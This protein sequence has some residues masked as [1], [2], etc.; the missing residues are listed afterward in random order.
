[1]KPFYNLRLL[2]STLKRFAQLAQP[3]AAAKFYQA[4]NPQ[5]QII[6]KPILAATR[7]NK[8]MAQKAFLLLVM[9]SFSMTLFGQ[10][11]TI[12][13]FSPAS[14][15]VG[16]LV[17]ING[18]N[19]SSPTAFSIGGVT[20]LVINNTGAVLTGFVMPG[21]VTGAISLTTGGGTA[22]GSGNFTVTQTSYPSVQQGGE[23]TGTGN[24]GGADQGYSLSLSAD[25]NTAIVGGNQDN[26]QQGA[27][28]IYTRNGG[29]WNQQGGKLVG[30]G[31]TGPAGQGCSV[32][33]SADGNTAIVGGNQD[34]NGEG[35]AWVFT[36]SGGVWGQ[37]GGKLVGTG[38]TGAAQQGVS[39]SLSADGNT[40]MMGGV[41][42][43]SNQGAAWVFTR[44]GG[45]WGQQG[46]KL[47][48]SD[49]TGAAQQ[50]ISVSLSADGNTAIVGGNQDNN[51]EGAAWV[52]TRS[53]GVWGQQG[54][55]LVGTG[56]TG[57]ANQGGSVSL[58]ADGNTAMVGGFSDNSNQGGAWVFTR[59]RGVWGQQGTELVGTGN[60]GEAEQGYSVSLSADGNTA[61]VGGFLDNSNQGAAWV[62]TRS[63]GVWG[64]QG[65][66]LV[67]TG[68]TGAAWQGFSVSLSADG[69]T[70][71]AGGPFDNNYQGGAWVFAIA[72]APVITSFS[73]SSGAVGTLVTING[74][75]L[76]DQRIFSIGGVTA[77]V[78]NNT[79]TVLT[80]FVMPGAVTG[81]ISLTTGG[82]TATGSGNFTV[83]P[84]SY[85][86][87]QQGGK[88]T[89][90]DYTGQADQGY[91]VAVSAG[92]NTAIVGGYYDNNQD[93]AAWIYTR[94]GGV[95]SQQGGKLVGTG[96]TGAADQGISVSI[97]A[98]G[99]TAIVGGWADNGGQGAAWVFTR[100]GGVWG[101]QGAKLVGTGNTG[102]A[103]QG[104]SVSLS[105]DGNT[106]IVGGPF[107][108]GTQGAAWVYTRSNGVW[109]QQGGKLVGTGNT[110]GANQG[111]SVSLSAD[112]NTAMVGG[113]SDNNNVGASWIFTRSGGVWGQQ[114]G[115]LVGTGYTGGA[116]QGISVS[117]SADGNTAMVGGFQDYSGQG[118]A[119]V[120]TRSGG[121]WGQQGDELVGT[122]STGAQQGY[123]VSLSADGN[124]AMVG[125]PNDNG[126][127]GGA[128]V[129]TRS[130]GVWGQQGSELVGTG[131]TGVAQQG[132]SVSLSADGTTAMVGGPADNNLQGG[133]W[134]FTIAPPTIT[135]FTPSRGPVGTLVTIN[136]TN[137]G[138]PTA[139]SIG[140]VTALV[141]NNTGTVLTG[142]VMPGAVTGAI[143]LTTGDGTTTG[144]G[145]FTV[146][147]TSY[148][149]VQQGGKLTGNDNTGAAQQ[150]T[151]VA[152]SAD[153]NTAIVGGYFDNNSNGAAWIY[154][155]NG[156]VWGQQG[157]KL[158]GTG[159]TGLAEQGW[160]VAI[161]AD[162]NTAI[163]G[164]RVDN[165][166]QGAVWVFTRS[167]GVWGQQGGKLV[168]TGNI[169]GAVLGY[170][171]SLSA[172]GNTAIA[173]GTGDNGEQG[174]AWV[175][176]RS[177]GV[178]GQQGGKLVGTG[179]TGLAV[180]GWSVSL[181]ADGNTAIVGGYNDNNQQ[182]AAW[183]YTRNGGVWGQQ[184]GKLVGTGSADGANQG[185]AVSLSADG[186]TAMVAGSTDNDGEGAVWVYTRSGGAWTQQGGKLVGT[187]NAG[188]ANQGTAVS[189]S[190]DGNIALVGGN[191]DNG[192][193]GAAW[194][195][196]R[197][198]G[199]WGQQ[200]NK[201]LGTGNTGGA[202]Q[203]TSLSLSADGTTAVV[204]G[205]NDNSDQG[206]AWAYT[207]APPPAI[208]SFSPASGAVGTLVTING[209]NL[210]D[211]SNL[212]IGGVTA[213]VISNTGTVLTGFV[214]PGAVTGTVS[215]TTGGG[216]ATGSSSFTVTPTL[217][218]T[219]QQGG[220]LTASDNTGAASQGNSVAVSAD[221]NTAIVGGPNDN[222]NQGAAWVYTR[223]GGVWAQQG[224][225]L[226]GAGNTGAA[227]QGY[228]VSLSADGNTAIVGARG[229]NSSQGAAW[230][231]TRSGGVWAQQ[232]GKLV[233]TD[234]TG[235]AN[236]G[237]SVSISAD[238]NTVIEGGPDDNSSQGAAWIFTRSGGVWGQQGGKM[239]GT[240]G[241]GT[242]LQGGSVSL[243]A[244]GNTAIVGGFGDNSQEGA[245]WVFTRSGGAWGQQG[246]K[247]VGTGNTGG[248]QQGRSV[249]LSADGNTAMVGGITDNSQQG[250]AWVFTRSGGAW[251]QQGGK[252]V[253]TGNTGAA[254]QGY[255][256]S[257]S[258]DGNT[259]MVSGPADN[260]NQGAAWVYTRSGGVWGQ[261]GNKLVGTG[262][263]GAAF[264]GISLSLSADGNT[265][266]AG[267]YK[268]NGTQG[269]AW[270]YSAGPA[271]TIAS[272]SPASGPVG[273]LVTI[274]G[275]NLSSPTAF[276]IGGVTALVINNTGTVLTGFVMPGAVT[277]V[278]SL[279]TYDGT[280]TGSGN[281]TVTPTV[282]PGVQQGAKLT[283]ND[284]TG[285]A[286]QGHSVA[287]SADGNT[288]IVGGPADNSSQ[289]AAWIYTRSGGVWAQQGGKLVGADNTGAAQQGYSVSISADGN[290]VIEGG[291]DDN[292]TQ[293]AAWVFTR[294]GGVWGQQGGKLVGTGNTGGANQGGS[295]SLSAD[296]N[297]AIL[298][299]FG[300][301]SQEGAA[302]VFTRRGGAWGQQGGKLVGTGNTGAAQQG[303]SV[304]LSA[305]GNTA[306]VGGI[307]DNSDQGAAWV[308][309]LS[310]GVWGQQGGK[311]VGTGNTGAADQGY[312]V[313]L[314]AD[315]NTAMVSG[316]AD[317]SN[318]G[319]AW[320]YT[321]SGG[322]WGQQGNKL[323]GTGNTGAAYQGYS[324]S[325]S[326]DGNTAMAGGYKDNGAQ[327]GA[328]VYTRSGGVW[329]QQGGEL[330]GTG[331]TGGAQ[332]GTSVSLS[333]DGT[334]A[335][336]GGPFDNGNVGAA[337]V[338]A[339][340][341]AP[342]I[343]SFSPSSGAV[344]TLVT[345]NGAN[346]GDQSMFSIGGV[347]ALVINNTGTVLTGFVMPGAV[348][349]AISLTTGGGT[350]TGS[351]NFT[352][353][354]TLYPAA[355]QGGKLTGTGNAGG[356]QQGFAVAVS[357]DGNTAIVGG[358]FDNNGQG[359]AWI[360]T[361]SG[362]VWAQQ[363]GKLV[364]TGNTGTADQGY[365]VSI[366]ADGNTAIV[367]GYTD[368]SGQGAAWVY[369][370]SGGVWG[371]QGNKLVGA[372][373]TGVAEQGFSVSLSA[374]G[375]TA[376]VGGYG[377]NGQQGAA[378]VYTRSAGA[379]GQQGG[380]LVG[381]GNTGTARQGYSVSISAD[382]N[383]AIVGGFSDNSFEGAAWV[384]TR[385][386]G[387]WNQQ[388]A[389]LFGAGNS[390]RAGQ[391]FSVSLSADGNTAMVGGYLDNSGRGAAWVFTRSG[392]AW[393]QQG[394]KLVG[395]GN[396]GLASQG[397][398]VSLSADGNTAM[399]GGYTDNSN[400]GAAWIY[401]RS[402]GAWGQQGGKLAG[403]GNTG[404]AQQGRS[405]SLSADG[406][407]AMVG[408]YQDNSDQ[409]AAWVYTVT[410]TD[411]LLSNL[412]L[413][414]GALSPTFSS[415][416][417]TYAAS[418]PNGTGSVTV[419]PTTDDP[420][421]TVLVNG[422][423]PST[424][425]S[426]SVGP[427]T[428][429][430]V[431]TAGDG[432]TR[433]TYTVVVT[434]A[435]SSVA[436]LSK[437]T[438]STGRL[439]PAFNTGTIA[440]T[441]TVS[442]TV[443]S[444]AFRAITTDPAATETINGTPVPEGTISPYMALT[445][446]LNTIPVV[447]TAA[448]GVTRETYTIVV[449]QTTSDASLSKLTV[450]S[451]T[452]TPA[453]GSGTTS[454]TD[455]VSNAAS[456]IALR[457]ITT[458]PN[459]TETINGT[460][461]T[462]GTVSPYMPLAVGVNT[463]TIISTAV[464]GVTKDTT[465]VTVTRL[466]PNVATLSK[467]TVSGGTLS[468]AFASG[469]SS[470][471]DNVA[472]SVSTIALRAVTTDP[473]ATETINGT[474]LPEGT[475]SPYMALSVGPNTITIIVTAVDGVT[476]DTTTI[477]VTRLQAND[478]S[479]VKL[480]VSSGTLSPAFAGGTTGYTDN[481]DN[482]VSTIAFRA[483]TTDPYATETING[484][485]VPEGTV[486]PYMALA[487]GPNTIL[488][489]V[490]A[491]DGTTMETYTITVNRA[492]PPGDNIVYRPV[493]VESPAQS[494]QLADDG[495]MVHQGVSPNGDGIDDFLR[496][497]NITNYPDNRLA[498]M[499]RNGM[500]VYEAKGYDNAARVFDGHS[501]KN[502]QM[503]LPGTYFYELD[504]IVNGITKHKTGFLVLKY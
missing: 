469:T 245:A 182:G 166:E 179:N 77:L 157:G 3:I 162:G 343:T 481:V 63:G 62:Y 271:A 475:V 112:G 33:L 418:V 400:Q 73:P 430:V 254:D 491:E 409:G 40:A 457:A 467:L 383:T 386:G 229:D 181:S 14:G 163:V 141:I 451:G 270:V 21:A 368:N 151:S 345:I 183:V 381:T 297:T 445:P 228:S 105:A 158:V 448:D 464:D 260:S 210:G 479:L 133:A 480:T 115:K 176:T 321:R 305:D 189:L 423:S 322:A 303:R 404:G 145:N 114:G 442:V 276:S 421:A 389:K 344:G 169:G 454:Y 61:M 78:I 287:V 465:T 501:N 42:D 432:V 218:P 188:G 372:G 485:V 167:G 373:S 241:T 431:I 325:L 361:R 143:S 226:V 236:Q 140:G 315:G 390:G 371:Q 310:G 69:T 91:S 217:Y 488:I 121:V 66:K 74:A 18:A 413:S 319:A 67:G 122:G 148:P 187:G 327:G 51:G 134:V 161:S 26:N 32:S 495:I 414:S 440:Y 374:D 144:S 129:F 123:S 500:L 427:N 338:F 332:Q 37:Q 197:N 53:G 262:N 316:P 178:W 103:A 195:Y 12:T 212:S 462:E 455:N 415:G 44:S 340:A 30:T 173:G 460:P 247:L 395:T 95:W 240:G 87:V 20:A 439:L 131:I 351:G 172:D 472:N 2:F 85:P 155:R 128:W 246:G 58:S 293:G 453:S 406:T 483:V 419:T 401:T 494:P 291:P 425:V 370:R 377:D 405:V 138:T 98:D 180:Q 24:T 196:T 159:N 31:N 342:V 459:A 126:Q 175:F 108:N 429:N 308:Y 29:V 11:P 204:G 309:T 120:F 16:T 306:M 478:A 375:N 493:S 38:N 79:G 81:A 96:N 267:G 277:G 39:V 428:I 438:V 272:F 336:V 367:G 280:T 300:D 446:G 250:A 193:Q 253:G 314:S 104:N 201:L 130:G 263:S 238:G 420:T 149:G 360:Y 286:I 492:A 65:S 294:S 458:D 46:G 84:T 466:L 394:G 299:G 186:N 214:M 70:A 249:S 19:L 75:N 323:V 251:G 109:G 237:Y 504:Y 216:T 185:A 312:A 100:S 146:T 111:W 230:I 36:R 424:P 168:G 80:G 499:N 200:G 496:I 329:G 366:S 142:F 25:G 362:G 68:N 153:G 211:Q 7:L 252:L 379:W 288:A 444:I 437:L 330:V 205:P 22:T 99:N 487:I 463:I 199:V 301:N 398:S 388:G 177:G 23:L 473:A 403:T 206:A 10:N 449:N 324:V 54:G 235:A 152:V 72:P 222:N 83:T 125:G 248:A 266:M 275:A 191:A 334:T 48:A 9:L 137:L 443:A 317:N 380:K 411:A 410:S 86:G 57:G 378:W 358:P 369:T 255:A 165:N 331:N 202:W 17:T 92:G 278:L 304:S 452:L 198:G 89:G 239:V 259:A 118:G 45:V 209:A 184:G 407:T 243:S 396:T 426:L 8:K 106:A 227:G 355:Q 434:E 56:N 15:A 110:G 422:F 244:D 13:S 219:V 59:S 49:N 221:G 489:T 203:G 150:G 470:Y 147:P 52:F 302:W 482:T 225:K 461:V 399:V 174:A 64:Q 124:T 132:W 232:G 242:A 223:S 346:L 391:G 281:F 208:T 359:A 328:W 387:V 35:A 194:V 364:G 320:V 441:D 55:K 282:Y 215:L 164:G 435:A 264:Q 171:V 268:D 34:N 339:L 450:S 136:G 341:P 447:I 1:M 41:T 349:G 71:I 273:T 433:D 412:T 233:G 382:G 311:L 503:Q 384:F 82:G 50:G 231:Y 113:L 357:A 354:P 363:G 417:N 283:G 436:S 393:S 220:K 207:V 471:T 284:N 290:T 76:G 356:A 94:S 502:G 348:T 307:T 353:T 402:G 190:A 139:F 135:S 295:V 416:T 347:T 313:S 117:L 261:Q 4:D 258:A 257:L 93:G 28:W 160:S 296:G 289:G 97:S 60:A 397:I 88:L 476:Q 365:S 298:G 337:W 269:A 119:W 5:N 27:V 318:Q 335:M 279:T 170:S 43:N 213:L 90:S 468:P 474:P 333:A 234:N 486:S 274:N 456:S 192:N 484:T 47:L 156:G 285:A 352:V 376:I 350:A 477:T 385:S 498:I 116:G 107:D 490:T 408:G 392:G 102:A 326:A 497:D 101:Q 127:V 224:G 292:N 256:V 154:T 265:A 6:M